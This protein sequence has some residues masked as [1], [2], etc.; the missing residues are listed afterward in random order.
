[1]IYLIIPLF[2]ISCSSAPKLN[3]EEKLLA[4][5][6]VNISSE[7]FNFSELI[8]ILKIDHHNKEVEKCHGLFPDSKERADLVNIYLQKKAAK[9]VKYEK[10]QIV[11]LINKH[12]EFVIYHISGDDVDLE[13]T[14]KGCERLTSLYIQ[15]GYKLI[16]ASY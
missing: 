15:E 3:H 8:L 9:K 2:L 1:M 10:K 13:S 14:V 7:D 4:G 16:P 11:S 6:P 5:H 12:Q